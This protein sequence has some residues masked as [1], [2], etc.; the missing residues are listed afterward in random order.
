MELNTDGELTSTVTE[1]NHFDLFKI[2]A[3]VEA[4][5]DM[6]DGLT[7]KSCVVTAMFWLILLVMDAWDRNADGLEIE[8]GELFLS[9][10][11]TTCRLV[12]PMDNSGR[13]TS[14]RKGIFL[15]MAFS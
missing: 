6:Y 10:K 14:N 3:P 9:V 5:A 13:E 7:G 1:L 15:I 8:Y 4:T 12:C 2:V 11:N